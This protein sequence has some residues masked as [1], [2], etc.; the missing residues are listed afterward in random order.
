MTKLTKVLVGTFL[1]VMLVAGSSSA[2]MTWSRS[3]KLGSR[4]A[5]VKDLQVFLNMCADS[6][7]SMSG[8]GSP[9]M[10]TTYFG[11][12]TKAAVIKWQAA[13]GV[14]PAS[15]LF[16]PLSRAKAAEL[17]ASSN[18]CGGGTV[19]VTPQ[20]GPVKIGRAHV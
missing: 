5:D 2:A 9:G 3:L 17:Q 18:V 20:S 11:P 19:V 12:A 10:E 8:A 16:G 14:S 7:V 6:K 13:R 15:G 1:G 4:G